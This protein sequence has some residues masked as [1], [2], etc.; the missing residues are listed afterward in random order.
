MSEEELTKNAKF[1]HPA[2]LGRLRNFNNEDLQREPFRT[3]LEEA[4]E[5]GWLDGPFDIEDMREQRGDEWLPVRRFGIM[6]KDKLRP[7]DNCKE[8]ML[9]LTFGC[10][11]KIELRAMEH[12]LFFLPEP[13]AFRR[14]YGT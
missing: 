1:S 2:I 8:S 14:V 13:V 3:T 5:K 9:N 6:Q 10:F 12:I 4:T 7:I 11:E